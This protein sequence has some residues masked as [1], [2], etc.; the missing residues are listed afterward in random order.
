MEEEIEGEEEQIQEIK[1][2]RPE[3]I[4]YDN[5]QKDHKNS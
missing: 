4:F 1:P 5:I 3:R 2:Q